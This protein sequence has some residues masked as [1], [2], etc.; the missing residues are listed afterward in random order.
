MTFSIE[1]EFLYRLNVGVGVSAQTKKC[2]GGGE[3]V[4]SC[5]GNPLSECC[6]VLENG[7]HWS[8]F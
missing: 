3:I 2:N 6:G 7:A 8:D 4:V 5:Q 1:E